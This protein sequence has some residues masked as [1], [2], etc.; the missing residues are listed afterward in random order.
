MSNDPPQL[1][2]AS[3]THGDAGAATGGS[4]PA[5]WYADPGGTSTFRW[6]DGQQWT[7][8]VQPAPP[9]PPVVEPAI[10]EPVVAAG[11]ASPASRGRSPRRAT[12]V[13]AAIGAAVLVAGGAIAAVV[14]SS[15][16]SELCGLIGDRQSFARAAGDDADD[17]GRVAAVAERIHT[18]A[19]RLVFSRDLKDAGAGF[20]DAVQ[21]MVALRRAGFDDTATAGSA[22]TARMAETAV[23]AVENLS[24]MQRSCG[25]PVTGQLA[26]DTGASAETADR[27]AQSDVR[28]AIA[29]VEE[30]YTEM[31]NTYP[32]TAIAGDNSSGGTPQVA[33]GSSTEK[34]TLSDKTKLYYVP[35]SA[36][37]YRICAT[38][39]GGS[40]KWYRYDSSQG[41]SV[42][43][44]SP[45]ADPASCA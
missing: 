14:N 10:G 19:G 5:G 13:V 12:V 43:A 2:D 38:N 3:L 36:D 16:E 27:A 29:A 32:D 4:S 26:A 33:V 15:A 37:T 42:G 25:L 45:P 22:T 28:G 23:S 41:G 1:L 6:W 17:V 40:G 44:V 35:T 39:V 20:A 11:T 24:R 18:L 9:A 8:F 34:I 31:G 7:G 21:T 30:A